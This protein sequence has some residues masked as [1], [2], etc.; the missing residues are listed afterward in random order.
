MLVGDR[1]VEWSDVRRVDQTRASFVI[2]TARGPV[3]AGW[4]GNEDRTLLLK[5]VLERAKLARSTGE[6]RYG[7][8]A[9][10]VPRAQPISLDLTQRKRP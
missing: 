7:L 8:V 10:F 1:T 9:Q 3:S 2:E 6:L 5:V 4:L